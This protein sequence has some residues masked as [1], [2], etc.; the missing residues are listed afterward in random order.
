MWSGE[1]YEGGQTVTVAAPLEEI[2]VFTGKRFCCRCLGKK[3]KV[4]SASALNSRPG[5]AAERRAC[6]GENARA[7]RGPSEASV[8][9]LRYVRRTYSLSFKKASTLPLT[10]G[11]QPEKLGKQRSVFPGRRSAGKLASRALSRPA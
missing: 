9:I 2:P 6:A 5:A 8:K 11:A 3:S 10:L 7:R 1:T 4:R